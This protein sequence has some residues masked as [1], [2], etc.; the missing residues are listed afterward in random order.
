MATISNNDIARAI[1]LA[2]KGKSQN[3]QKE[4]SGKV[5][6]FLLGKRV[7]HK[8]EDILSRLSKIINQEENR[9]IAKIT[10]PEKIDSKMRA[11]L[12]QT[13]KNRYKAKE[14]ILEESLDSRLLGGIKVEVND[15]VIDL[16]INNR[17]GKLKEYLNK[18]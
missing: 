18:N 16:S 10:S 6:R 12:E 2:A 1:Y 13:L 11:H 7:L 17:I 8:S 4:L 15:E 5:V 9:I 14:V 3:E